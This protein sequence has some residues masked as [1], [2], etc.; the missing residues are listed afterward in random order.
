MENVVVGSSPEITEQVKRALD[1]LK[2]SR[3]QATVHDGDEAG[4][5]AITFKLGATEQTIKFTGAEW[6][7][8]GAVERKII[9]KLEI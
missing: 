1:T 7:E 5:H 8:S 4:E 9:D 2:K 3:Y 6:T